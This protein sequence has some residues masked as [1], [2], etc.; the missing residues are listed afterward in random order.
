ME[1][2]EQILTERGL[3]PDD[4]TFVVDLINER[5]AEFAQQQAAQLVKLVFLRVEKDSAAGCALRRAL[6]FSGG[7]SLARA[8]RDFLITKQALEC[9]QAKLESQLGPL[10]FL[11]RE[12]RA[13]EL[14]ASKNG[15]NRKET[16]PFRGQLPHR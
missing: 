7:V 2:L 5:N 8:A 11:S 9:M 14:A 16:G 13:G 12:A 3:A 6:G 10:S 15:K 4:V 1:T